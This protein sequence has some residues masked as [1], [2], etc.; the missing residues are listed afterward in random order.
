MDSTTVSTWSLLFCILERLIS[1]LIKA[2]I[3]VAS[4]Y[5]FVVLLLVFVLLATPLGSL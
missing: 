4:T 1:P 5:F 2:L 3:T